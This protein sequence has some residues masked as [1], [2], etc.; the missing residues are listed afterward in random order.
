MNNKYILKALAVV[1]A[2]ALMLSGA[3]SCASQTVDLGPTSGAYTLEH[4]TVENYINVTGSVEG[5]NE[6]KITSDL[7]T[8]VKQLNVEV[9]SSVKEGDVLCVF[10]S[11]D[12]QTEYD[13]LKASFDKT[14]EKQQSL[15]EINQRALNTA[16]SDRDAA[17]NAAQRAIDNAISARDKAYSRYN[18]AES[19]KNELYSQ[20]EQAYNAAYSTGDATAEAQASALYEQYKMAESEYNTLGDSLSTYDSAIDEANAAYDRAVSSGDQAVQ[21]AQDT[22]NAEKF[23]TDSSTQAQLDKLQDKINKCTVKA[24]KDGIVTTLSVSEG[25]IPTTDAIMT[26]EDTSSLRIKVTVKETDILSVH[27]GQSAVITTNATGNKEFNGKVE[28]VINISST[29]AN[30]ITGE[31][32]NNGYEAEIA[33]DNAESGLLIG[34]NA[35]VKIA[36]ESKDDVLA[37]PYDSIIEED[38]KCYVYLAEGTGSKCTAK[39]VEV[40]KGMET[41]YLTEISSSELKDGDR[42]LTDPKNVEDGKSVRV[43]GSY[44]EAITTEAEDDGE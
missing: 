22:I 32:K 2:S 43:S 1:S 5:S 6:V 41:S 8:K 44:Y 9:G 19:R 13:N 37:V 26:L 10:D 20:Y 24:P 34:M 40:E 15:H 36:L 4:Q 16:K 33:V 21:A 31:T 23:E 42:I 28:R 7:N 30:A 25:S 35:K 27:E 29:S 12:L 11:S 17:V 38:D 39:K 3:V 18:Q 14:G